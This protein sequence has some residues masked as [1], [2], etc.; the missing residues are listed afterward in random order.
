MRNKLFHVVVVVMVVGGVVGKE[1]ILRLTQSS[2][3]NAGT[4]LRKGLFSFIN[5]LNI[6]NSLVVKYIY[7]SLFIV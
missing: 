5:I 3:A 6:F 2:Q 4:E 7:Q 1:L